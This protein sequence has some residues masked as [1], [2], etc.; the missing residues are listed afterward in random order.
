MEEPSLMGKEGSKAIGQ[1][2]RAIRHSKG[3]TLERLTAE[4]GVSSSNI[5]KIEKGNVAPAFDTLLRISRALGTTLEAL[6]AEPDE[7]RT[8]RRSVTLVGRAVHF[9]TPIYDYFVHAVDLKTKRM[10]PLDM[11]IRTREVPQAA[12]WSNH[13]GEEFIYVIAGAIELHTEHY[14]PQRLA[15]GESAYIDSSMSHA[16]VSVGAGDAHVLSICFARTL[17]LDEQM[18]DRTDKVEVAS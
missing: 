5:S 6:I 11:R 3:W 15:A 8:A 14:A 13:E 9:A 7:A 18:K 12:D 4:S 2:L 1:R 16:F 17:P 10:I